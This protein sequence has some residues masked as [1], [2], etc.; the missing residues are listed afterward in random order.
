[1]D[2]HV[3]QQGCIHLEISIIDELVYIKC[4]KNF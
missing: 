2:N 3:G 4:T 1:M